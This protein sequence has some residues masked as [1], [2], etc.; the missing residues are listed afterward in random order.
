MA[1][2]KDPELE[3]KRR[4]MVLEAVQGLLAEA[5][6][7]KMTLDAVAKR[8]GVSKGVVTYWFTSKDTLIVAAVGRFHEDYAHRL[9]RAAQ[10]QAPARERMR[11]LIEVAFPSR[12][13]VTREVRFQAEVWS[14][15]KGNA[16]V[17]KQVREAYGSFRLACEAL[18]QLGRDAGYI[19]TPHTD[20]LNRFV[21]ALIDGLSLHIA[22]D[23]KA[24]IVSAREMLLFRLEQWFQSP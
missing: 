19:T 1:R 3:N 24:D 5:S 8:A 9:S 14:F 23:A 16:Q 22:F 12:A 6:W 20:D 17:A 2:P 4:A 7:T 11:A 21:H 13:Q 15:A 18:I 10:S